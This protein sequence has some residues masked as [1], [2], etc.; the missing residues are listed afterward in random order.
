VK[1][2]VVAIIFVSAVPLMGIE[3]TKHI[4]DDSFSSAYSV[5]AEDID[6]DGDIDVIGCGFASDDVAWWENNGLQ[7]FTKHDIDNSFIGACCAFAIDINLD[8]NID[9]LAAARGGD[10]IAWWENDGNENFSKHIIDDVFDGPKYVYG[11]D[12]H[13]PYHFFG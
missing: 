4:I 12:P 9:I 1:K 13:F 10:E 7:N 2:V 3:F 5:Y 6:S 8:G 11:Y